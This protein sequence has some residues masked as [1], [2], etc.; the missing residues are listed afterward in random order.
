[1]GSFRFS[2]HVVAKALH[3]ADNRSD[4]LLQSAV[5]GI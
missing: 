4:K 3:L 1:M 5:D 2:N